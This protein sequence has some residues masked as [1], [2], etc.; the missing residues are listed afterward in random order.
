MLTSFF[1]KYRMQLKVKDLHRL[2]KLW[3][4]AMPCVVK[5]RQLQIIITDRCNYKC[6]TCSKWHET[7]AHGE[8]TTTQWREFLKTA[9][10]LSASRTVVF[11]GGEPLLRRDIS[12]LI[13]YANTLRLKTVLSTNGSLLSRDKL[14]ELQDAG[15]DY[16]MISLNAVDFEIHDDS[17]GVKG[18]CHDIMKAL[19][20]YGE[21]RGRMKLGIGAVIMEKNLGHIH[22][23][24]D[25]VEKRNLHGLILQSYVDDL[26]HHPLRLR[27]GLFR[28]E[29]W[30]NTDPYTVKNLDLLDLVI[31]E[32]LLRQ[33]K[34]ARILNAPAQL[35][36]M[37]NFY[38]QPGTF[39]GV[40][41]VAGIN[42]F[43][44]DP[45]GNVR[46]CFMMKSIGNIKDKTPVNIWNSSS[47]AAVKKRIKQCRR[48]C[49]MMNRNY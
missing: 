31:G 8:L 17:R 21:I 33:K 20:S 6:P 11:G 35:K 5:P 34:G 42:S 22:G 25:L 38:R 9:H 7:S 41:C 4:S 3:L 46:S 48:S 44:V 37:R 13:R 27:D 45:Y 29:D 16:L 26:A 23:L 12:E 47:A 28:D 39:N 30:Y 14:V 40:R 24:V 32:L 10:S 49:R 36:E 1:S 43:H 2:V 18:S 15:L 19:D